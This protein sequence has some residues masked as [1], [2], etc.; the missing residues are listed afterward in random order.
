LFGHWSA[1]GLKLTEHLA[2]LDSGCVWGGQLSALRLEDRKALPKYHAAAIRP[3]E[4]SDEQLRVLP[5]CCQGNSG[6]GG[7]PGTN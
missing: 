4:E 3:Q 2:G 7:L 6:G 1:L 5:H